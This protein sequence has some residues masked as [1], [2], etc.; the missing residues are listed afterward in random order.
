[1]KMVVKQGTEEEFEVKMNGS[2]HAIRKGKR[3][4]AVL[5]TRKFL[6]VGN[7]SGDDDKPIKA[8]QKKRAAPAPVVKPGSRATKVKPKNEEESD[9]EEEDGGDIISDF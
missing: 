7:R 3:K 9:E 6:G 4:Q 5:Q 1:M 2:T 8:P